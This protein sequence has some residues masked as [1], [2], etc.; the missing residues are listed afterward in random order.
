MLRLST[1]ALALAA[2]TYEPAPAGPVDPPVCK[3]VPQDSC[4]ADVDAS[5][6]AR[7]VCLVVDG[8]D[9]TLVEVGPIVY[10]GPGHGLDAL[11]RD[12]LE[13]C[14]SWAAPSGCAGRLCSVECDVAAVAR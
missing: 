8:P 11:M 14:A 2:C 9:E 12:T 13:A 4:S 1:L 5:C 3:Y 7:E 10:N 6:V